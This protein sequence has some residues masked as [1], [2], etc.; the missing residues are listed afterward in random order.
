MISPKICH[1]IHPFFRNYAPVSTPSSYCIGYSII[2]DTVTSYCTKYTMCSGMVTFG[3]FEMMY[4]SCMHAM[5][6]CF[7][8]WWCWFSCFCWYIFIFNNPVSFWR[9]RRVRL[10]HV[11]GKA[12]SPFCHAQNIEASSWCTCTLLLDFSCS[13]SCGLVLHFGCRSLH[14]RSQARTASAS[15]WWRLDGEPVPGFDEVSISVLGP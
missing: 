15:T 4:F 9:I 3:K 1:C 14:P 10:V 7:C 12:T 6:T 13:S 2:K 11:N 5:P 8:R